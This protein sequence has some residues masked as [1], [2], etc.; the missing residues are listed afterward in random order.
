MNALAHQTMREI[1]QDTESYVVLFLVIPGMNNVAAGCKMLIGR[2]VQETIQRALGSREL[3]VPEPA[4]A[5]ERVL[6][7]QK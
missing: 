7:M 5:W 4:S 2:L 6:S 3:L 1:R